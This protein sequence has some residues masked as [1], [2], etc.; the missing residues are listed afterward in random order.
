MAHMAVVTAGTAVVT[1]RTR[2]RTGGDE[3]GTVGKAMRALAAALVSLTPTVASAEHA[4]VRGKLGYLSEWE[5]TAQVTA[6][7]I[8][9]KKEFVGPLTVRHVGMCTT[10]R[11]AEMSGEIRYR[12]T[13][14]IKPRMTATLSL[15]GIPCDFEGNLSDTYGG[16]LSC[17]QWRGIPVSL[18]VK[19]GD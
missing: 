12:I 1:A 17:Q 19:P 2:R 7:V 4:Q 5:V 11:P 14:W 18:T 9:G 3:A 15:D 13:G 6:K 8:E 16:V 10:G